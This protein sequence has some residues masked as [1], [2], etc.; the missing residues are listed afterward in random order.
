MD[1]VSPSLVNIDNDSD[2][3]LIL[4]EL[5]DNDFGP[6]I[7]ENV[8]GVWVYAPRG[9][10]PTNMWASD[11]GNSGKN[12]II[13][14]STADLDGDGLYDYFLN[15]YYGTSSGNVKVYAFK[16]TGTIANPSF[17]RQTSWDSIIVGGYG[18]SS[19]FADLDG[20]KDLDMLIGVGGSG[21]GGGV[22]A[23]R[24]IGKHGYCY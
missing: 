12:K 3:D 1:W 18:A 24:N 8:N 7:Y 4:A 6:K 10:F 23:F 17:T 15:K 19:A 21:S 13:T 14:I 16:N 11:D 5:Y 20:D 2:L 22:Y 9:T